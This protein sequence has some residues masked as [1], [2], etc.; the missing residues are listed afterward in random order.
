MSVTV[1]PASIFQ[2]PRS[3]DSL[4]KL[5]VGIA[6]A[7]GMVGQQ[8]IRMLAD[9]PWFEL[10]KLAAS[11][12]SAGKSYGEAV[13]GRRHMDF[14]VPVSL[15]TKIVEDTT[16]IEKLVADLDI[17]FCSIDAPTEAVLKL[18]DAAAKS[19]VFVVSCNSAHRMDPLVP[20]IVPYVNPEH[21][22]VIPLQRRSK[23]YSTGAVVVKSNCSIQSYVIPLTPLAEFGIKNITVH[24]EQAVSGAGKTL[25]SWP[26]MQN[27]VI[28]FIAGEEKKSQTEPLKIWG[29][30]GPHGIESVPH[31]NIKAKCVRVSVADGHM[32]YANVEFADGGKDVAP[33]DILK[34]WESFLPC[35]GLPSAANQPLV[36]LSEPDRPQ[37]RLDVMREKGMVVSVGQLIKEDDSS[38]SFIGL[39][40]NAVLGAA[41]GAVLAVESA[42]QRKLVYRRTPLI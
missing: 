38:F 26:E 11:S 41:G 3:S 32:A 7:T 13:E 12:A 35:R 14:D 20:I 4:Q 18:E 2:L 24:S 37:P 15:A 1:T 23:G 19:G 42:V 21:L 22:D 8:F 16:D 36:Y 30:V 17:L 9:H 10:A 39:S 40:H 33:A 25:A 27:N 29:R 28:P 34:I 31:P 5:R 6:G